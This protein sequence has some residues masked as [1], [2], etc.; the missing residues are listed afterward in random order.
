MPDATGSLPQQLLDAI[1]ER[2][3][4]AARSNFDEM[5]ERWRKLA[6]SGIAPEAVADFEVLLSEVGRFAW[7]ASAAQAAIEQVARERDAYKCAKAENDERFQLAAADARQQHTEALALAGELEGYL[8]ASRHRHRAYP[9]VDNPNAYCLSCV[10]GKKEVG[11]NFPEYVKWPCP[12]AV[13][14][15]LAAETYRA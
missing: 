4:H 14:L 13:D 3:D 1:R 11:S 7:E 5:R 12:D 15:G 10:T 9:S 2:Y 6:E 8:A